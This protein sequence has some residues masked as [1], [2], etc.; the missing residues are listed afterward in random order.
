MFMVTMSSISE[1]YCSV[2]LLYGPY[3]KGALELDLVCL[4]F[5]RFALNN[6]FILKWL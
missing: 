3:R 4:V 2:L 6:N 5:N 1:F